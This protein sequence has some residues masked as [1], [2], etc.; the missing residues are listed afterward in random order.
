MSQLQKVEEIKTL[1]P[2]AEIAWDGGV[3]LDNVAA[4]AQS[5]IDVINVGSAI[6]KAIQPQAA[7]SQLQQLAN[8]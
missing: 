3:N 6:Q 5:G 7:F 4:L 8:A 2:H 1:N